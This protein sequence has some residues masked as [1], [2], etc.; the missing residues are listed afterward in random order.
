MHTHTHKYRQRKGEGMWPAKVLG[1]F[2]L[3]CLF[4]GM[5]A[6]TFFDDMYVCRRTCIN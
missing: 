3:I 5:C 4:P 6:C 1:A 2:L